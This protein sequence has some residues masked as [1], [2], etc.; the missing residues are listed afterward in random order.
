MS[1][2]VVKKTC[3]FCMEKKSGREG[4]VCRRE[5]W[6]ETGG[7]KQENDELGHKEKE[8]LYDKT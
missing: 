3:F 1:I 4:C 8:S 5:D 7:E 2:I 6:G